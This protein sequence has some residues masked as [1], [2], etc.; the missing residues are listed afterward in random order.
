M[1]WTETENGKKTAVRERD[2]EQGV[3]ERKREMNLIE[4][5]TASL[6]SQWHSS[7]VR[8][9]GVRGTEGR[10]ERERIAG[11]IQAWGSGGMGILELGL[12]H[13][14]TTEPLHWDNGLE[15]VGKRGREGGK[16]RERVGK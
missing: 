13:S 15:G 8:K 16:E 5:L 12:L 6:F 2:R 9:A 1:R 3:R 7:A 10:K 4:L 14:S 11:E